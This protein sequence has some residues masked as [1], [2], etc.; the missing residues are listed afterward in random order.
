M[1]DHDLRSLERDASRGNPQ[2]RARFLRQVCRVR[3]HVWAHYKGGSHYC[4]VCTRT[5]PGD[6]RELGAQTLFGWSPR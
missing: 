2:A 5:A 1:A 3:G 4:N 6:R